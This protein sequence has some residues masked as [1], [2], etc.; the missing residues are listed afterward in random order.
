MAT[1]VDLLGKYANCSGSGVVGK[2]EVMR[3]LINLSKHFIT[4]EVRAMG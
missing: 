1:S 2:E 4:T 3:V